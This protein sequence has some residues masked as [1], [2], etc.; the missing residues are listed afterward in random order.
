MFTS[1]VSR[2]NVNFLK[3]L[4]PSVPYRRDATRHHATRL[5]YAIIF[6]TPNFPGYYTITSMYKYCL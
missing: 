4:I 1:P 6:V 2:F 3:D 5:D